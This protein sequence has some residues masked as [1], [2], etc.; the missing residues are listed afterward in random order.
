MLERLFRRNPVDVKLQVGPEVYRFRGRKL[1]THYYQS[2][3]GETRYHQQTLYRVEGKPERYLIH[4][5]EK[6]S[7][8]PGKRKEFLKGP[9]KD[10]ELIRD[11]PQL[12]AKG[13]VT[14]ERQLP[15]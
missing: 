4:W 2:A 12:A 6:R 13:G 8:Y 1:G 9:Y 11:W 10:Y 7:F 3:Y 5:V 15:V 14:V